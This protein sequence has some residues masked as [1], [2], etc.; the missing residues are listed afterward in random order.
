MLLRCAR[1]S[2]PSVR[3][4]LSKDR[5]KDS[6]GGEDRWL[7]KRCNAWGLQGLEGAP[8]GQTPCEAPLALARI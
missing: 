2:G 8:P 4:A 1:C 6:G 3:D 5:K 7:L